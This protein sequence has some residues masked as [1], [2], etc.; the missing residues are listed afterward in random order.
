MTHTKLY[1]IIFAVLFVVATAQAVI[2][3]SGLL[4]ADYWLA[5]AIIMVL[6]AVKALFVAVY[7]QHLRWE[8]RAISY[9]AIGGVVVA[10]AL[11]T[12]ASYSIT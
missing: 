5:F 6:S 2:E 11:T 10:L 9:L 4:A 8:P 7:Y 1:T 3:F 12:A